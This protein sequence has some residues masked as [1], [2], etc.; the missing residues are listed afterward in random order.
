MCWL[1]AGKVTVGLAQFD[2]DA[3]EVVC[4]ASGR[5]GSAPRPARSHSN[6]AGPAV[7]YPIEMRDNSVDRAIV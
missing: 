6:S 1:A 3:G 5:S 7:E 2:T 4:T